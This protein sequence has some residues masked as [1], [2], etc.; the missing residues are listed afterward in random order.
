MIKKWIGIGVAI[1]LLLA[2]VFSTAWALFG[3][4]HGQGDLKSYANTLQ[5]L[6]TDMRETL[7]KIREGHHAEANTELLHDQLHLMRDVLHLVSKKQ[8]E[9]ATFQTLHDL[10][11]EMRET[12][13]AVKKG[14]DREANLGKLHD[15]LHEMKQTIGNITGQQQEQ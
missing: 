4:P 9:E 2:L 15:Q 1:A 10:N 11:H 7:H 8:R 5:G 3:G 12:W 13:H 6:N 14:Q